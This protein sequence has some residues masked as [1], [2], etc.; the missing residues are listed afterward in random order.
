M[1][2]SGNQI[3]VYLLATTAAFACLGRILLSFSRLNNPNFIH[4]SFGFICFI[5]VL[6]TILL[7]FFDM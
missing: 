3:F 7:S 5:A 2:M 6:M 4:K 1:E